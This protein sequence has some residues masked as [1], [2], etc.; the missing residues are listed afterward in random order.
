MPSSY[1]NLIPAYRERDAE[2]L[3]ERLSN[4][5]LILD[6]LLRQLTELTQ[7]LSNPVITLRRDHADN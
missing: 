2:Q 1:D 4:L 7:K 3:I 5:V 6:R